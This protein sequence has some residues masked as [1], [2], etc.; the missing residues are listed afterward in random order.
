M[1]G[2]G[3]NDEQR[4]CVMGQAGEKRRSRSRSKIYRQ[5]Q[6]YPHEMLLWWCG[7]SEYGRVCSLCFWSLAQIFLGTRI[8]QPES[9]LGLSFPY[10]YA[11]LGFTTCLSSCQHFLVASG[12]INTV[13]VH[14]V[15]CRSPALASVVVAAVDHTSELLF[16]VL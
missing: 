5:N 13:N 8:E 2:K 10:L 3:I 14:L 1:E 4:K 16:S 11:P 9:F 7:N 6:H 15:T 12:L